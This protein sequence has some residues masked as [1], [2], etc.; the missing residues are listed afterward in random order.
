MITNMKL[1]PQRGCQVTNCWAFSTLTGL[2][3]SKLKTTLCS[4]P[5]ADVFRAREEI[6]KAN[7][8][9]EPDHAIDRVERDLAFKHRLPVAEI[10]GEF[11]RNELVNHYEKDDREE[12]LD[13]HHPR[14]DFGRL[15]G[16]AVVKR[17]VGGELERSHSER[18]RLAERAETAQHGVFE[19]RVFLGH[20]RNRHI[21]AD[22]FAGGLAHGDAIAV[23]GA[24]HDAFHDSLAAD[25]RFLPAFK[26]G[27]HL[28][29][30]K[31]AKKCA[32][33]QIGYLESLLYE[34]IIRHRRSCAVYGCF[35]RNAT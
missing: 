10:F 2:P 32:E 11:K 18:H 29:V 14:R 16:F 24:H 25:E 34:S 23:G 1:V 12:H 3:D 35:G 27:E 17:C 9:D 33:G 19:P 8:D 20:A 31:K 7:E 26:D 30:R 22:D 28:D 5:A 4:A 21:L 13:G 6:E 15:V